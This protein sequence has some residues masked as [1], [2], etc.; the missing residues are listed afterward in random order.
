MDLRKL[1]HVALLTETRH[2]ARAAELAHITQ[3]ALSRSIQAL[4]TE[5][6]LRLFDRSQAGVSV[7]PAG[8]ELLERAKPLLKA[9]RDLSYEM[10]QLR[11]CK[12]GDLAIG[13]GPFPAATLIPQTI[14]SLQS[15]HPGLRLS[16]EIHHT[17][18]LCALLE[19]ETI[20][21]FVADTRK[22]ALPPEVEMEPLMVQHGGLFCRADHPLTRRKNLVLHDLAAER[23]ASVQLPPP[24][25][26]GFRRALGTTGDVPFAVTC[27]NI[28]LLKDLARR[29]DVVLVCTRE[30]LREEL[31]SGEFLALPLAQFR[32]QP[33]SVGAV[34]LRNRSR[35]PAASLF[36]D[37]I[38]RQIAA[39]SA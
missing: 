31:A 14:A 21:L 10:T 20:S 17:E 37:T 33:V 15:S 8:R 36:I 39:S 30:A 27:D 24:L 1:Q 11:E 13:A 2:F 32:P 35:S 18:A 38:K 19:Q 4:E 26:A 5:L 29:S 28:Y 22:G 9:A 34:T 12:L 25:L 3:S 7:T 16:I 6:G 23:F